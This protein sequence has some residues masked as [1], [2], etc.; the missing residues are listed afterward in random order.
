[1]EDVPSDRLMAEWWLTNKEVIKRIDSAEGNPE[2]ES[3]VSEVILDP[4]QPSD[5]VESLIDG[6]KHSLYIKIPQD[7][8]AL[9]DSHVE[10]ARRWRLAGRRT[11]EL[12]FAKGFVASDFLRLDDGCYYALRRTS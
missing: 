3:L 1:M 12:C 7:H 5:H 11:F 6:A 9:E 2:Q 8:L 4:L 10:L